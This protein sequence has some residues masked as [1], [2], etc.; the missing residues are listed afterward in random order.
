[1][2]NKK[3]VTTFI[4]S[5]SLLASIF[6]GAL[7]VYDPLKLFH[8]PWKYKKYLHTNMRLQA[9][10][11]INNWEYDSIIL[12]TSMLENTSS[13]EASQ[14]LGGKFINISL[15]G[16]DFIERAVVLNYV[17]R[18]RKIK[19]VLY[20]LD[21]I[22]LFF[23]KKNTKHEYAISEWDYLYDKNPLNDFKAYLNTR[24]LQCLFSNS[25]SKC[26]GRITDF[27]R[28]NAWFRSY[29]YSSRF[30]GIDNWFKMANDNQI[31]DAFHKILM[32][33]EQNTIKEYQNTKNDIIEL[34]N[35]IDHTL[36]KFI[37]QY[38]NTQFI[39]F[40]PPY[41]RI[42]YAIN[43]QFN[44][45]SFERYKASVK[46][47]VDKSSRYPNLKIYG[48]GNH[49]F[50]DNIANYKD[51]KHY[52]QKINSW[53]LRAIKKDEGL[54]TPGNVDSYLNLFT[55]KA[56]SYDITPL[57][58]KIHDY[59]YPRQKVISVCQKLKNE[60][61]IFDINDKDYKYYK[62]NK[63]TVHNRQLKVLQKDPVMILNRL[64]TKSS[65]V[66]LYYNIDAPVKTLFQ[67]FYKE[68]KNATYSEANSYKVTINKGSNII[69]LSV[70]AKYI[71]NN[72]RVDLVNRAGNYK[73][74]DFAIY[75]IT[76]PK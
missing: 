51:L 34:Q 30:G 14:L 28:P 45:S 23:S 24:T 47:L 72:L 69:S 35:N 49:P 43:A 10:G 64:R 70:P 56:L 12:G 29:R 13:K 73:I 65:F 27:D 71:N 7:F 9:A 6:F 17:L 74:N 8:Q 68:T 19:Q 59:L 3:N 31:K 4:I 54:L 41:S 38:P 53:M 39:L 40:F 22:G 76:D 75:E 58:T 36:I 66:R 18:K 48:W 44:P 46:Y 60:T 62:N 25:Q 52:H 26:M 50:V 16:S 61:K 1:M 42:Q 55:K 5:S 20:S 2:K 37:A 67:L 33:M 11:I 21:D 63:F 57:R 32:T 15:S